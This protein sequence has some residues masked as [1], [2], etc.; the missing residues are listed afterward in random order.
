MRTES[1]QGAGYNGDQCK[2]GHE[3]GTSNGHNVMNPGTLSL[4][5]REG[6]NEARVIQRNGSDQ[7]RKRTGTQA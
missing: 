6:F 2:Y 1:G 7:P 4:G 5:Q 3:R